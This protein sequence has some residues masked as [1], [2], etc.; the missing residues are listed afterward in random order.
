MEK[1]ER[2]VKYV[3]LNTPSGEAKEV[4]NDLKKLIPSADENLFQEALKQHN[5]LHLNLLRKNDDVLTLT[6]QFNTKENKYYDSDSATWNSV[7]SKTLSVLSSESAEAPG[8]LEQQ[9]AKLLK[10]YVKQNFKPNSSG[11]YLYQS[12][13]TIYIGISGKNYK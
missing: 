11:F 12:D 8:K 13:D 3:I 7:D 5:E 9:L 10:E 4:I 1:I 6:S 2:V